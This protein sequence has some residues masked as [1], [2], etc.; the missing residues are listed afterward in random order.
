MAENYV[1]GMWANKPHP[2]APDF[3]KAGL[4]IKKESFIEWLNQQSPDEKGY[5]KID[6]KESQD[7]TKYNV[8]LNTY[9]K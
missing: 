3:V 1:T 6:I 7:G 4:A 8:S 2:N 5:V 9:K